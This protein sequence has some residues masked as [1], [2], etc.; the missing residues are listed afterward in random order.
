MLVKYFSCFSGIGGF[1]YGIEQ[2]F[3]MVHSR[4]PRPL[5]LDG[6]TVSNSNRENVQRSASC[7]GFS[8]IDKYA[9]S[10]YQ[11][12]YPEHKAYGDITRIDTSTL[13]DFDL[14]VG[15]FPCQAFSV[16]GK[17]GGFDDTRGTLFFE[18]A[19]IL[20][21]KRPRHFLFENVKGLLS[22]DSGKTFQ[23]ILRV[24]AELGY[25][26]EW[27]VLNSKDFGVPQNRERIFLVGHF[28]GETSPQ[29]FPIKRES[30]IVSQKY[31]GSII[32]K[33]QDYR[34]DGTLREFTN[35]SPALRAQMGDNHPMVLAVLTPDR[36]EK[37]QNGRRFKE[38]GEPAFT[39]TAQDKHGIYDGTSIRRLTPIECERLQGFPETEVSAIIEV[40]ID[41]QK[42]SVNVELKSLKSQKLVGIVARTE[43]V[44]DAPAVENSSPQNNQPISKPAQPN[45]HIRLEGERVEILNQEKSLLYASGA[46]SQDSSVL[47]MPNDVFAQIIAGILRIAER[48]TPT[49]K[50]ASAQSEQSSMDQGN[51]NSSERIFGY[52]ITLPVDD[53]LSDLTILK[54]SLKYTTS[55]HLD[56][57]KLGSNLATLSYYVASAMSGYTDGSTKT[58]SIS[59]FHLSERYGWTQYGTDGAV[60]DTQRY[61]CLGNAVTTNVI[62]AI[63]QK[64]YIL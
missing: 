7:I 60:S 18:L 35:Y 38:S 19:R 1:E 22:H 3:G 24:L 8:E 45:V 14:L 6:T 20:K 5:D 41:H 57:E 9:T 39:L 42:N 63:I 48:I 32:Q 4:N 13:P 52:E 64:L 55:D 47:P 54:E 58:K 61:K 43:S 36:S 59:T 10:I 31:V 25:F 62:E 12:H 51:G 34:E 23:T 50:A 15:G 56:S 44:N 28:G 37:R 16:A 46:T 33:S 26:V 49:G 30:S 29:V 21:D 11:Y 27:Q 40:C 53:V 17:R 2:V